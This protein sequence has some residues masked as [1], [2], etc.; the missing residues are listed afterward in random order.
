MVKVYESGAYDSAT[1]VLTHDEDVKIYQIKPGISTRLGSLVGETAGPSFHFV[2]NDTI[3]SDNRIP[4]R[5]F[6][7]SACDS[8]QSPPVGY[9]YPDGQYWD[10]TTYILPEDAKFV[11]ATLYYQTTSKEYIEFLRDENVTNSWGDS[12]YNAWANQGKCAPIAMVHDT[13]S[14]FVD[15]TGIAQ[16]P[17]YANAFYPIQPNPFNPTARVSYE[18]NGRKHVSIRVY[19]V[20][21][22]L[23]RTLVNETKSAGKHQVVWNGRNSA[24][25]TV[26]TSVYFF[27]MKA[28][29]YHFVRK[30]VL[31]K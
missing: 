13:I 14:V 4:P 25:E 22:R 21:G 12:L 9:S 1:G 17:R 24:G 5:G 28:G 8:I 27:K 26:S 7:Y 18:V 29:R 16:T 2:L 15:P 20:S 31:L 3:Y 10:E 6:T 11:E 23:I 30:A 19:D